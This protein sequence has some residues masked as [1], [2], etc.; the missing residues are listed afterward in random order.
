[1]TLKTLL[2][3]F[4]VSIC[5]VPLAAQDEPTHRMKVLEVFEA[6]ESGDVA[7]LN[8][9]FADDGIN[10]VS[11]QPRPRN[12]PHATFFEA[13]SFVG[14][15]S[16]RKVDVIHLIAE[17]NYVSV[18]SRLCGDHTEAAILGIAPSGRRICGHYTNFYRFK[19]GRIVDNYVANDG[20][21]IMRQLRSED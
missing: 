5:A 21:A 11:G 13:A 15:L 10:H 7:V 1:M 6:L 2:A 18:H 8:R 3:A 4:C 16:N 12:G 14:A 9:I 19:D 20:V 17:G